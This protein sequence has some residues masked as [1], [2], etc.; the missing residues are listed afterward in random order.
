M[1]KLYVVWTSFYD[2]GSF[3]DEFT[4]EGVYSSREKAETVAEL[5]AK[6]W[7]KEDRFFDN[8]CVEEIELDM[9][10]DSI[11]GGIIEWKGEEY[12]DTPPNVETDEDY[13]EWKKDMKELIKMGLKPKE[14]WD[15]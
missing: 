1:K 12:Y 15:E 2:I 7:E 11:F 6:W 8:I 10:P 4:I 3:Q 13:E 9:I 5:I 14:G